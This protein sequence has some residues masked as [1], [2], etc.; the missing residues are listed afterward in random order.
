MVAYLDLLL[1]TQTFLM[2]SGEMTAKKSRSRTILIRDKNCKIRVRTVCQQ[3][4]KEK[5]TCREGFIRQEMKKNT[6]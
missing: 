5:F 2:K 6:A 1:R 3:C 4:A